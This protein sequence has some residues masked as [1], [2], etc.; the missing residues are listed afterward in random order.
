MNVW[1]LLVLS[2]QHKQGYLFFTPHFQF[3][4]SWILQK[5]G[6][7]LIHQITDSSQWDPTSTSEV[8]QAIPKHTPP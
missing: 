2:L 7:V 5:H 3:S 6:L 4:T 1:Q 8:A